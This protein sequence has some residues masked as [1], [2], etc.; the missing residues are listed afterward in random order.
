MIKFLEMMWL[1]VSIICFVL[2]TYKSIFGTIE[3][4][5][6]FYMFMVLAIVLWRL[7]RR[8]RKRMEAAEIESGS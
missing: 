4:G 1:M 7:R 6:F 3:D 8:T 2:A 5:L